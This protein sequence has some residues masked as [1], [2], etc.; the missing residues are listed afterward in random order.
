MDAMNESRPTSERNP[1][2]LV[3]LPGCVSFKPNL[4]E[5]PVGQQTLPIEVEGT[6]GGE[7]ALNFLPDTT[8][9]VLDPGLTLPGYQ[10]GQP[11]LAVSTDRYAKDFGQVG[12]DGVQE[13][14]RTVITVP[15]SS[16]ILANMVKY[17]LSLFLVVITA[18]LV[19]LMPPGRVER[20]SRWG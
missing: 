11:A 17:F 13:H 6:F 12:I 8:P 7:Y 16:P 15:N 14:S 2:P 18:S 20:E 1:V 5:F 10:V 19:F 9:V 4:Q 3:P